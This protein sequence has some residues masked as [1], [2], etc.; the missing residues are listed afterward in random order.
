M[1]TDTFKATV[2]RD[3]GKINIEVTSLS[4]EKGAISQIIGVERC[5]ECTIVK[6]KKIK[7]EKIS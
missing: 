2:K 6:L 4:G 7:S 5:P 3:N 1:T